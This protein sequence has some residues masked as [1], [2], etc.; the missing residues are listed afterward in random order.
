MWC[1]W[2]G[3]WCV[4]VLLYLQASSAES[5][6]IRSVMPLL[7]CV[8]VE[9]KRKRSATSLALEDAPKLDGD[10]ATSMD[11]LEDSFRAMNGL[12]KGWS[13]FD[14]WSMTVDEKAWSE[15]EKPG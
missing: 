10:G 3:V 11:N 15:F 5:R 7:S 4:V 2:C 8:T 9:V 13:E 1:V 14:A 12:E 6:N